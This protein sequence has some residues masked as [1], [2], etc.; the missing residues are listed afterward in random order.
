MKI[1]I[2]RLNTTLRFACNIRPNF[3]WCVLGVLVALA[4]ITVRAQEDLFASINGPDSARLGHILEYNLTGTQ[5][6]TLGT[7]SNP[8]GLAFDSAGD[9][10][11]ATNFFSGDTSQP[12]VKEI[13]SRGNR[14]TLGRLPNTFFASGLAIGSSGNVS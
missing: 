4:P 14:I 8:R 7:F 13:T 3:L 1:N 10:F 6:N 12:A 5:V 2:P 11:V 9:L